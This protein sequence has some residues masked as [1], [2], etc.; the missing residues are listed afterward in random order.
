DY[1]WRTEDSAVCG[2]CHVGHTSVGKV[3]GLNTGYPLSAAGKPIRPGDPH[4]D[5][6]T[7]TPDLHPDGETVKGQSMQYNDYLASRHEHSLLTLLGSSGKQDFCLMCHSTDYKLAEEGEEPTLDTAIHDIECSLCHDMHGTDEEN[8]L[9]LDKWDTC[10]QCH[11]N[12]DRVPGENPLPPH[13][14]VIS[15]EIPIDGLEGDPWMD[16]KVQCTDCHMPPMGVREVP[17]DIPSHTWYFISPEKS[18]DL[19]MPNS[20][21]VACH[22]QGAPGPVQTDEEA[23]AYIEDKSA[24]IVDLLADA[25]VAIMDA[26]DVIEEAEDHGFP[27]AEIAAANATF[28]IAEFAL[29]F[30]KRDAS[31]IH[32]PFFQMDVLN[33]SIEKGNEVTAALM[34]GTVQGFVKDT[35]GKAVSGAE[36]RKDDQ[37]WGTTSGDGSFYFQ[38]APG[39]YS[40]DVYKGDK[41]EGSF[42]ATVNAGETADAGTVKFKAEDGDDNRTMAIIFIALAVIIVAIAVS[43]FMGKN[44]RKAGE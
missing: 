12:G 41:K 8:N 26:D 36:V 3:G 37:V 23:L 28:E 35:D 34:P 42:T 39:D 15:G 13:K 27:Q 31:L 9:R 40:F 20:C 24:V 18:I 38:I 30:I 2:N 22:K 1:I 44:G 32:N 16:G 29:V 5:F 43:R 33:Y 25:E 21:T 7:L 14:E 6:L 10:V 17:Y 19:G 11:R 4:D